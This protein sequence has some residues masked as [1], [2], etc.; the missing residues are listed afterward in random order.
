M[1]SVTEIN[2]Q[3]LTKVIR[4]KVEEKLAEA[5]K[6]LGI[7]I[8]VGSGQYGDTTGS[9]KINLATI[10]T[11]GVAMTHERKAFLQLHQVYGL[12]REALD[13][14][15]NVGGHLVTIAGIK[16]RATK[17]NILLDT[18]DGSGRQMV[19]PAETIVAAYKLMHPS[20][21]LA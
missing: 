6:E 20:A 12:P 14:E 10:S 19:A 5:A 18:T 2:R 1:T 21:K 7:D 4:P 11:N 13:A 9:L 8:S 15:I 17:N 16:S 3:T